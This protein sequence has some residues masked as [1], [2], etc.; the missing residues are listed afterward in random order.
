[1]IEHFLGNSG[2]QLDTPEKMSKQ[3]IIEEREGVLKAYFIKY[4]F[5]DL[6]FSENMLPQNPIVMVKNERH[7]LDHRMC[8]NG[9]IEEMSL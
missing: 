3:G 6:Q 7:K 4:F 1:M 5:F 8:A 2:R 9:G